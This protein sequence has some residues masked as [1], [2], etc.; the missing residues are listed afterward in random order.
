MAL[1]P[2]NNLE[3]Y[4]LRASCAQCFM[5]NSLGVFSGFAGYAFGAAGDFF[6]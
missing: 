2:T 6:Y 1:L 3:P 5:N 4:I